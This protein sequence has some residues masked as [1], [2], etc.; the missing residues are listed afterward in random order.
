MEQL[1]E[2]THDNLE[3]SEFNIREF[4]KNSV[5]NRHHFETEPFDQS[6]LHGKKDHYHSYFLHSDEVNKYYNTNYD[7]NG[8]NTL[9]GYSEAV[10][11][12]ELVID[13]DDESLE[14]ALDKTRALIKNL[15]NNYEV[16]PRYLKINF[17]GSKGFHVRIPSVL[18]GEFEPSALLPQLHKKIVGEFFSSND[19]SD[20]SIYKT[21]G[22]IRV[23]NSVN[24]KSG[25]TAIPLSSKEIFEL[26][27]DKIKEL[28]KSQREI[29]CYESDELIPSD[30]LVELK[31]KC[32]S[33]LSEND[34][35][36]RRDSLLER[37]ETSVP[38]GS[39]TNTLAQLVGTL[40]VKGVPLEIA[41]LTARGWNSQNADPLGDEKVTY[42]VKDIYTR[43]KDQSIAD[44][45]KHFYSYETSIYQA[46]IVGDEFSLK[47]IGEKKLY[48]KLK[49]STKE[50]AKSIF[51]YV[52]HNNH[53][54]Q[55]RRID[56]LS[57][58]NIEKSFYVFDR[59]N[60]IFNVNVPPR[61]VEERDNLFIENYLSKLFGEHKNFI[62]KWLAVFSYTNYQ[63]LPF[64]IF[65]GDRGTSKNTFAEMVGAIFPS[66]SSFP[67]ELEG[68]FNP[69]AEKKLVVIDE[70]DSNGKMQ[71][72]ILKKLSGQKEVEVNKKYISQYKARNNM[73]MIMLSNDLKAVYV[74]R[75]EMPTDEFNNQF[76]VYRFKRVFEKFDPNFGEK[77][78]ARIGN[79]VRTELKKVFDEIDS[80]DGRYSIPVPITEDE[81]RLFRNSI[82]EIEA[83]ADDTVKQLILASE[84]PNSGYK[85]FI[86]EG[87]I[88]TDFFSYR[89][90]KFSK[91]Q[92]VSDLQR[93][94]YLLDVTVEKYKMINGKRPYC[95][96][97]GERWK[98]EIQQ[99]QQTLP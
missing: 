20:S 28:A 3:V 98:D 4:A 11:A 77:L 78:E 41:L 87:L 92:I 59:V 43:Y 68:N 33:N 39:R 27:M 60:G 81:K 65:T 53:I 29:D 44:R 6:A 50:E 5:Y 49:V 2:A 32:L 83:V 22:L 70:S 40:N 54:D 95:Y 93:R 45:T 55:L 21:I 14:N 62:K 74:D 19:E 16:D 76:F 36:T 64:L 18:F 72:T 17:S 58:M 26:S 71:Y 88:P 23:V 79:Y 1:Q 51:D 24:G 82:T 66:L 86:D 56:Y 69:D 97:L 25:L 89:S 61:K 8:K 57:N 15:E 48:T 85:D 13:L 38:V 34:E 94:N 37:L 12:N 80:V 91:N 46:S 42:T 52:V 9:S 96:K 47:K 63:K 75:E 31:K 73:N 84:D 10:Y 99:N 90:Q 67:K 7:K 35:V 30:V